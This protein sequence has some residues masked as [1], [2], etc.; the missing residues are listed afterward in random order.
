MATQHAETP[1]DAPGGD[2][3][4]LLA[5][6]PERKKR[7]S[8]RLR[9]IGVKQYSMVSRR[10]RVRRI[11]RAIYNSNNLVYPFNEYPEKDK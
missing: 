10:Y 11:K 5:G 4:A 7:R 2:F 1:H 9:P 6:A 3:R 8:V